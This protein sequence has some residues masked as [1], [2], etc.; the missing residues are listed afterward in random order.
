[1]WPDTIFTWPWRN[2]LWCYQNYVT[3]YN[4]YL[5][6]KEHS[7]VLSKLCD[8]IQYLLAHEGT[9]FGV[10]KTMW[11]DIIFTC[12]WR[13]TL[14]CYQNYVTWYNTYL[15]I[16]NILWCYQN[17]VTWYNIYLPMKKHSLVSSKLC[18]LIQ[19]LLAHEGTFFDVIETMWPDI[20]TIQVS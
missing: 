8:L 14:W 17:Y 13:N 15:P 16:R 19:Y 20:C 18:V 9:F 10:I 5:P 6:M 12:P 3:W 1:M 4:I 2:I 11:P 7:L